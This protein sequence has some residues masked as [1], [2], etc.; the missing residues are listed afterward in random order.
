MVSLT[1]TKTSSFLTIRCILFLGG[2][3][4]GILGNIRDHSGIKE[5]NNKRWTVRDCHSAGHPSTPSNEASILECVSGNE[6]TTFKRYVFHL[7]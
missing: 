5:H 6:V 3:A 1:M 4:D 7:D 2:F